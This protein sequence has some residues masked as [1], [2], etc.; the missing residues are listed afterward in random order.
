MNTW[1]RLSQHY[2]MKH[3]N[4]QIFVLMILIITVPLLIISVIIYFFSIQAVKNEYQSSSNL[5]LTNLSFNIDQYLQSIEKGTLNAQMDGQLQN[6]LE[7]WVADGDENSNDQRIQYGNTIEHFVSSI[8][9]TIKNVDSVQIYAGSRVFYSA[10]FN[11]SDYD[12]EDFTHEDWYLQTQQSKGGIVLFGTH[13]PFHRVNAKDPVISIARVINKVGSK[14]PLGVMLIDIRLDSLREILKLSETSKRNFTIIDS[15]GASIYN[16]ESTSA[17]ANVPITLENQKLQTVLSAENG[18]FYAYFAG[19]NSFIN[20]VTSPYSG[21]KVIQSIDEKEMTKQAEILIKIILALAFLSL[22]TA[23][24]FMFILSA[25]VTK[26]IILLS[27]K[28]KMVGLGNFDVDLSSDRQDE[29]GVLYQG[30]RKMLEDLQNY[31]ERSSMAKAQQK[32]AQY[33]ALKSQINPHFLANVLETIQ[34]KAIISGQRDVG[35]MVGI[36]GRLF[37][38]HI[39]TGK[40]TVTLQ[41]ELIHIRLYVKIQQLRF[42][43]KIQYREE[44]S[45][46]SETLQVLHFSLQ[47][48]IENAFVHGLERS[49]QSGLLEV[50]SDISGDDLL[51]QIKDN[52]VGMDEIKLGQL[53]N[54]LAQPSDTLDETHIGIK[55]VHDRIVFYFGDSY[56]VEVESQLGEGTI[57][58]IRI[59]AR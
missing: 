4:H 12:V 44:L 55:N 41:E 29:F 37:R 17:N 28:V 49:S 23:V 48:L 7:H 35:E 34:M 22:G 39:Q 47:P 11:R 27:R 10:N 14:Q 51:I 38:I 25:R 6:A 18:S 46:N 40:E 1:R 8:E 53:R 15:H 30:I 13:L 19:A 16:S 3:V 45:V 26:P 21:W 56:G 9:M 36:L 59:P 43:D 31:I 42:G 50:S 54:R 57:V 5:I 58:R 2:R 24:L 32:V 20:F 52:G 33:G